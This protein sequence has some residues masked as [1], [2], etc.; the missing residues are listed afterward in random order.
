MSARDVFAST[1]ATLEAARRARRGPIDLMSFF[2]ALQ[3]CGTNHAW[4]DDEDSIPFREALDVTFARGALTEPK[5]P[6]TRDRFPAFRHVYD[7]DVKNAAADHVASGSPCPPPSN[8]IC[9]TLPFAARAE[10]DEDRSAGS[11]APPPPPCAGSFLA[12]SACRAGKVAHTVSTIGSSLFASRGNREGRVYR[13]A[14]AASNPKTALRKVADEHEAGSVAGIVAGIAHV[15]SSDLELD[16]SMA[17]LCRLR[18]G[19]G[20]CGAVYATQAA[21]NASHA[22]MAAAALEAD[23][24]F[25][26]HE[27]AK[28]ACDG[29]NDRVREME[30]ASRAGNRV[31][32]ER[33]IE[34]VA[35]P[36]VEQLRETRAAL[37]RGNADGGKCDRA[38]AAAAAAAL[39]GE[40]VRRE[41]A[42]PRAGKV[43]GIERRV[44]TDDDP[45]VKKN[46]RRRSK[47]PS[48]VVALENG[49]VVPETYFSECAEA[50]AKIDAMI[51]LLAPKQKVVESVCAEYTAEEVR[52]MA[53]EARAACAA[54]PS[55]KRD[56]A[57]ALDR[58]RDTRA[59][60]EKTYAALLKEE[61]EARRK[62]QS[63]DA[64][65]AQTAA[66]GGNED[67]AKAV[68]EAAKRR[69]ELASG[70]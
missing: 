55:A 33:E 14:P 39:A 24:A 2:H 41:N 1:R 68:S 48:D 35:D 63:V 36:L 25:A 47:K 19:P 21:Y 54:A 30:T 50:V 40:N 27:A 32:R 15:A 20:A 61:S 53:A 26:A 17:M 52:A 64:L 34:A 45:N 13:A 5:I 23:A 10:D 28:E 44:V 42:V 9:L 70:K 65:L 46:D 18:E 8:G 11:S 57:R 67:A 51:E 58:A 37:L 62:I 12:V 29:F 31:C 3:L 56:Y 6:I 38:D 49:Y 7:D 60:L 16:H 66:A 59:S 4:R 43:V 22:R 69:A